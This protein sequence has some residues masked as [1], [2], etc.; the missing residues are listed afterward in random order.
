MRR[1]EPPRVVGP[2]QERNR[3]RIVVVE[4][5]Q[6]KSFFCSTREEA[7]KLKA[8]FVKQVDPPPSRRLADVI[9]D[10]E[11]TKVRSG[12]CKPQSAKD[13][14]G[15]VSL[16]LRPLLDEEIATLTPRGAVALYERHTLLPSSHTRRTLSTATHR[17]DLCCTKFFFDWTVKQGYLGANPFKDVKPVGKV[18]P[19]SCSFVSKKRAGS[20][21]PRFYTLRSATNLWPWAPYSR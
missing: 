5:G 10:W 19:E 15:R 13:Q 21:R 3:W 14:A 11:Q 20:Q 2:Y 18:T 9:K 1:R 6:R 4:K 16:F 17:F 12:A 8:K 7:L